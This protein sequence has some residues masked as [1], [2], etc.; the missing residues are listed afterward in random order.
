M[1]CAPPHH[2]GQRGW[3]WLAYAAHR[4]AAR[5]NK[6]GAG[7]ELIYPSELKHAFN[8]PPLNVGMDNVH[9]DKVITADQSV[10]WF[11]KLELQVP[12]NPYS[13]NKWVRGILK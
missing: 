11:V 2:M 4:Q 10:K 5:N 1:L 3:S 8:Y 6:R 7:C 9:K 13:R 12:T